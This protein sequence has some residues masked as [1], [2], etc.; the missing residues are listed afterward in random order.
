MRLL[1]WLGMVGPLIALQ[2]PEGRRE[3]PKVLSSRDRQVIAD[4]IRDLDRPDAKARLDAVLALTS[5]GSPAREAVPKLLATLKDEERDVAR[6]AAAAILEIGADHPHAGPALVADLG[7]P[8][9]EV[10]LEAM[11]TIE[12]FFYF[13]EESHLK[14]GGHNPDEVTAILAKFGPAGRRILPALVTNLRADNPKVREAAVS[15]LHDLGAPA[16]EAVPGLIVSLR[17]PSE[18]VRA[19]VPGALISVGPESTAVVPALFQAMKTGDPIVQRAA[20]GALETR[21]DPWGRYLEPRA[22]EDLPGLIA[23]LADPDRSVRATSAFCLWAIHEQSAPANAALTAALEDPDE[24]VRLLVAATLIAK[25][26]HNPK[27][28]ATLVAALPALETTKLKPRTSVAA[29][30]FYADV[31]KHL[32]AKALPGI[33][34]LITAGLGYNG[35]SGSPQGAAERALKELGPV[36]VPDLVRA[37]RGNDRALCSKVASVLGMIGPEAR[38]SVPALVAL[39][40]DNEGHLAEVA[41][42]ALGKIGPAAREAIPA[43]EQRLRAPEIRTRVQA[44]DILVQIDPDARRVIP[45]LN[46]ALEADDPPSRSQAIATLGSVGPQAVPLLE[47][48]L[49]ESKH[50]LEG[51]AI[52]GALAAIDPSRK[53]PD[54]VLAA[55][56]GEKDREIRLAAL[57]IA[58]DVGTEAKGCLHA[59]ELAVDDTDS[60]VKIVAEHTL[61]AIDPGNTPLVSHL[62]KLW[63]SGAEHA[64][65]Q[66]AADLLGRCGE[67]AR[68]AVPALRSGLN[69][70]DRELKDAA[71]AALWNIDRNE[72][73]IYLRPRVMAYMRG[74]FR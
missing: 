71:A 61:A 54:A 19:R 13:G 31:L 72:V 6:S 37:L 41:G 29:I 65:R 36:A 49:R 18:D 51:P 64:E 5:I 40:D 60:L 14:G 53:S 20:I 46:E 24:E 21:F 73:P 68:S 55:M 10:R 34:Q 74:G 32:G 42:H 27:A 50:P 3:E 47:R 8:K 57:R 15:L 69:L 26:P 56:L 39:L 12:N 62:L 45:I 38:A 25:P 16:R 63:S 23:A 48:A 4:L 67:K 33:P 9:P 11:S 17:D 44:A 2:V 52:Y 7:D 1:I 59:V 43:L 35:Q 22:A 30:E 70:E 58:Q 66:R 28:E